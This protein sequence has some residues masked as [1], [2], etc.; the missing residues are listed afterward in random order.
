MVRC[1]FSPARAWRPAV[2]ARLARTLGSAMRLLFARRVSGA[3]APCTEQPEASP[4][5]GAVCARRALRPSSTGCAVLHHKQTRVFCASQQA[6][7][8]CH[9]FIQSVRWLPPRSLH[10]ASAV[11]S[12]G[13]IELAGTRAIHLR[14]ACFMP[15]Q[16][17]LPNPSLKRTRYGGRQGLRGALGD[18]APRRPCRPPHRAA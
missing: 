6:S 16:Q 13:G 9:V 7:V 2:G 1:T 5:F 18:A 8:H 10:F 14:R 4:S 12:R 3:R 17:A 11:P 15:L